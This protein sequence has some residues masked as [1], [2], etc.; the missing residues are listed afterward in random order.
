MKRAASI[1]VSLA[2]VA[3]IGLGVVFIWNKY[4]YTPWT[5]DGRVRGDV[6]V[7]APDVSGWVEQIDAKNAQW[8]KA[9]DVL[10]VIDRERYQIAL[11]QAQAD[12]EGAKVAWQRATSVFQR[13]S[14]L[15]DGGVSAEEI[16]LSRLDMQDKF[17]GYQRAEANVA[18]AELNLA[19]TAYRAPANGQ[20]INLDLEKGDY[21]TQGV[22]RLSM[23]KTGSYY[24]T[25]YFE[26]TKIPSIRVGDRVEIW[27]AAGRIKLYGHVHAINGGISND[28]T[29]PGNERLPE[30]S[31]TFTW[32][33]LAQRIPVDIQIDA[34]P[35][36]TGMS[37]GMSA[38]LKVDIPASRAQQ[39]RSVWHSWTSDLGAVL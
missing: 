33:R 20:I 30:V 7:M 2:L 17:A 12:E 37:A 38:T 21:V 36:N 14:A 4:M 26:E 16:Q 35:E 24:V 6:V 10:F 29:T 5:R 28:D 22:S 32:I 11:Q 23:V 13:R 39:E 8:V 9:G 15:N 27:L 18:A 25:G 31:P 34:I 1:V 3:V 19:R